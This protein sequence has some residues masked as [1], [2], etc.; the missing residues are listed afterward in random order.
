MADQCM[1]MSKHENG[2]TILSCDDPPNRSVPRGL[3]GKYGTG[4]SPTSLYLYLFLRVRRRECRWF[5]RGRNYTSCNILD[6][7]ESSLRA[8]DLAAAVLWE[9]SKTNLTMVLDIYHSPSSPSTYH[10]SRR[11]ERP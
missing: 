9:R 1:A 2:C 11:P 5:R 6:A 7:T 10:V 3:A 4:Y 8:A